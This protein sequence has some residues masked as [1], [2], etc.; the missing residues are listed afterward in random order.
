MPVDAA[1][2]AGPAIDFATLLSLT[3][4]A[5]G[6]SIANNAD[7]SHRK[8]A[9]AEKFVSCLAEMKEEGGEITPNLL[10]HV[11]YSVLIA[12]EE[13]DLLDILER[14]SGMSFLRADTMA[15]GINLAVVS[16]TL[17]QWKDAVA[18]G[19]SEATSPTVRTCYSK[20]LLLF[21]R[22]GLTSVWSNFERRP[23]EDQRR[24]LSPSHRTAAS[25]SVPGFLAYE[26]DCIPCLLQSNSRSFPARIE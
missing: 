19:T 2:I 6:Y 1:F 20:I 9:D 18:A 23:S 8:L 5:L 25:P 17:A 4:K 16:G 22:A 15:A 11:F 12:A 10:S 24:I 26:F 7:A 21:D 3:H 14:T 13:R